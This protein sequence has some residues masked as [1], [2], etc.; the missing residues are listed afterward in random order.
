MHISTE[1][2][3]DV[4]LIKQNTDLRNS[5]RFNYYN[6]M[7]MMIHMNDMNHIIFMISINN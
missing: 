3:K 1:R 5:L 6:F 4:T 7:I 2:D